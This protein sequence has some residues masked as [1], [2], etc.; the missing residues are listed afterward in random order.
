MPDCGMKNRLLIH[1]ASLSG[2]L[3][4]VW[5]SS[6]Q[7]LFDKCS[8]NYSNSRKRYKLQRRRRKSFQSD[9]ITNS[10]HMIVSACP[11]RS[12]VARSLTF[13]FDALGCSS[14]PSLSVW[15]GNKHKEI[16]N[17]VTIKSHLTPSLTSH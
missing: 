12:G 9:S 1:C 2:L 4:R 5:E 14:T 13:L 10:T 8:L 7:L 3:N 17:I 11:C 16:Q 6:L 15:K